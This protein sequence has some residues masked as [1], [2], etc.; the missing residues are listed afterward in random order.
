MLLVRYAMNSRD[1]MKQLRVKVKT[2]SDDQ[3][4]DNRVMQ[5]QVNEEVQDNV[6]LFHALIEKM[7]GR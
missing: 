7:P 6:V 5:V 2:P 1:L 4:Q 3:D